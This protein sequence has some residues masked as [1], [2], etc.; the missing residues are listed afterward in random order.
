MNMF[1]YVNPYKTNQAVN[2]VNISTLNQ[3]DNMIFLDN[4]T[5]I[6]SSEEKAK[7]IYENMIKVVQEFRYKK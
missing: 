4:I 2:L 1:W 7:S 6:F 3:K 5:W